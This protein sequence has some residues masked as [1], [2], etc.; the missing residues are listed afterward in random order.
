MMVMDT[1]IRMAVGI[2]SSDTTHGNIGSYLINGLEVLADGYL[3]TGRQTL[4]T[5]S[6]HPSGPHRRRISRYGLETIR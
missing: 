3:Y 6:S 1:L 5:Q 2:G 4:R